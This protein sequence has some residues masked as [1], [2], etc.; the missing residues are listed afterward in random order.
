MT[1]RIGIDGRAL[2][3][4]RAGIGRY[5]FE[6]CRALDT[7]M[8]EAH[9]F[10]YSQIPIEM[11][12]TSHRWHARVERSHWAK[13]LKSIAWL[14][15]RCGLLCKEDHLDVFW[16]GATFFPRLHSKVRKI[17]TVYDLNHI[18][19]PHTMPGGTL[20]GYRLFFSRDVRTAD[21]VI[22]ISEG[23]SLRLAQE[24]KRKADYVVYPSVSSAFVRSSPW[25]IKRCLAE[26]RIVE[27]YILAV[28]TFEPRKNLELL[29]RTFI[30][31][32]N[33][34]S[35]PLHKLVLAGGKGW[36][37]QSLSRLVMDSVKHDVMA[38]GYVPNDYLPALYSG[39]DIFVFPSSYEGFGIPVLEARACGCKIVTSDFPELHEAGGAHAI[40]VQPTADGIREGLIQAFQ[41]PSSGVPAAGLPTWKYG[42]KLMAEALA[43][44]GLA[45]KKEITPDAN[46]A[47]KVAVK[48]NCESPAGTQ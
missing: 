18:V 13:S 37:D 6:L 16:A 47:M 36:K 20:W 30:E 24:I 14:K 40:Y 25:E 31:M 17:S 3:G 5:I 9:F 41:L 35:L 23:T 21:A 2:Q 34:G 7:V 1:L 10:L 44:D 32:K 22:S 43:G 27:P 29:I 4:N 38:L 8:P 11:P 48:G 39:A 15:L 28:G 45:S 19:A 12:I 46:S 26:Y 33:A 42:A